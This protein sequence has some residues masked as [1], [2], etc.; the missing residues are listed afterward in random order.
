MDRLRRE[1]HGKQTSS[2][3]KP[4]GF[5]ST[6]ADPAP[7]GESDAL[8]LRRALHSLKSTLT[9][10]DDKVLDLLSDWQDALDE[11]ED[12][13]GKARK[14]REDAEELDVQADD[15]RSCAERSAPRSSPLHLPC[16]S[17]APPLHLARYAE[18][19][20]KEVSSKLSSAAYAVHMQ[21]AP[22]VTIEHQQALQLQTWLHHR[23]SWQ[24]V[25]LTLN[26][27]MLVYT[28]LSRSTFSRK[29]K[30]TQ[31][32]VRTSPAPPL[33]L[34]CN[35]LPTRHLLPTFLTTFPMWQLPVEWID[36]AKADGD[37]FV[38]RGL[39]GIEA[40]WQWRMALGAGGKSGPNPNP[41]PGPGLDPPRPWPQGA[42]ASRRASCASVARLRPR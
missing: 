32:Q 39:C 22:F 12:C 19:C 35:H 1:L 2:K 24:A 21:T 14:H 7:Y 4:L 41:N 28:K 30:K 9:V 27:G 17:R 25:R 8:R 18:E 11:A 42:S 31:Q 26:G 6:L 16:T 34:P 20:F 37:I 38:G 33:H 23:G 36:S 13:E 15:A 10:T 3:D 5:D 29:M 40:R